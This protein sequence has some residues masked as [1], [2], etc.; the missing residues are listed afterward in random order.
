[1]VHN[2]P[3]GAPRIF[4]R[5]AYRDVAEAIR[6]LQAAFGFSERVE[7]RITDANERV[8]LTELDVLDSRIMVGHEGAHGIASPKTLGG[9]T[10]ALIVYVDAI[11]DHY[12]QAK[13]NGAQ[14][15]SAPSDQFWGDRRYEVKDNEGHLWSFHQHIRDVSAEEMKEAQLVLKRR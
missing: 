6:F 5:L 9:S 2:P 11:D 13:T 14:I 4:A 15:V 12:A 1:M 8:I 7:G 3:I 10:Q